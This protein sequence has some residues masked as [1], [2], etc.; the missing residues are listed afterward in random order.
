MRLVGASAGETGGALAGPKKTTWGLP[1]SSIG[2]A[3]L[4]DNLNG[5][6]SSS[7]TL[8]A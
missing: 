7:R 6:R 3:I 1:R 5:V 2:E 4:S 8:D